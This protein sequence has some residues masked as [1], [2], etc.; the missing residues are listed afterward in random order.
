MVDP[1]VPGHDEN[2]PA[3]Q[4][5]N[6]SVLPEFPITN[7]ALGLFGSAFGSGANSS[8]RVAV[9]V[10]G[11]QV[12]VM[13]GGSAAKQVYNYDT[14][15]LTPGHD[16]AGTANDIPPS[17]GTGLT[18]L[19]N[20]AY[21]RGQIYVLGSDAGGVAVKVFTPQGTVLR[22][23]RPNAPGIDGDFTGLDVAWGELWLSRPNN[24]SGSGARDVLGQEV[25]VFDAQTGALKGVSRNPLSEK[26]EISPRGWWDIALVPEFLG[27]IVDRRMFARGAILPGLA[28]PDSEGCTGVLVY[29]CASADQRGTDSPWGMRWF[30]E[31][32]SGAANGTYR[33]VKE[34]A[35]EKRSLHPQ[36]TL[37]DPLTEALGALGTSGYY[38]TQKREWKSYQH[39]QGDPLSLSDIAYNNRETR[40]DWWGDLAKTHW[41]RGDQ[42]CL[43]YIVSDA[44]IFIVGAKGERHYELARG[45]QQ[46]GYRINDGP[47]QSIRTGPDNAAGDYC[48]DTTALD[49]NGA[50]KTP[51][52]TNKIELEAKVGARTITVANTQLRI[53]NGRP[54]G[55]LDALPQF[56]RGQV[57]L[58]G[59]LAD[60]WSKP[61]TADVEVRPSGGQWQTL[62]SAAPLV[63]PA[64][65]RYTCEW[66][67][68]A[69][70]YPDG[71]Y[72]VRATLR[73]R[74]EGIMYRDGETATENNRTDV[75]RATTVDNTPPIIDNMTPD[76]Y[77]EVWDTAT[78]DPALVQWTQADAPSGS[79]VSEGSVDVN[80]APD[81]SDSGTWEPVGGSSAQNASA[82]WRLADREPGF[83]QFRARSCDRVGNCRQRAWQGFVRASRRSATC[84]S[85]VPRERVRCYAG[86]DDVG[87]SLGSDANLSLSYGVRATIQTPG[88]IRHQRESNFTAAWVGFGGVVS[89]KGDNRAVQLQIGLTTPDDGY[90]DRASATVGGKQYDRWYSYREYIDAEDKQRIQC[91]RLPLGEGSEHQ[92][93]TR[94]HPAS[95]R[96][97][98]VLIDGVEKAIRMRNYSRRRFRISS[99]GGASN[100]Q[101]LGEVNRLVRQMG[102]RFKQVETIIH[103][104]SFEPASGSLFA[105]PGYRVFGSASNF[106]VTDK[107]RDCDS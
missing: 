98:V 93:T 21:Y 105:D 2:P 26:R 88:L 84:N 62:C 83:Y 106:C 35:I 7:L 85:T 29:A 56:V 76:L 19:R 20:I 18:T 25:A 6:A 67:T 104:S 51:D 33:P 40:I 47:L 17:W 34:F 81:G 86:T 41:Q 14:V 50:R 57:L 32:W 43:T 75:T 16:E 45:F 94:I 64:L 42:Q 37:L 99:N 97:G 87:T 44:D 13:A 80:T 5:P 24:T 58:M 68:A 100:T 82:W 103:T 4:Q 15:N 39:T 95:E 70:A 61:K 46:I 71:N 73:D 54:T 90:C 28:T 89:W 72:E 78:T 74:S 96:I 31:L 30:L 9:A 53:D 107:N 79:G 11:G 59:T 65:G 3:V 22:T 49:A 38:L 10:G 36:T 66:N 48:I 91:S 92:Y 1:L 77:E 69:G 60:D 23:L 55:T 63:D 12:W 8:Q 27:A 52:G 101:V 102:G